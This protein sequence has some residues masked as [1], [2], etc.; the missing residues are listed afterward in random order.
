[1]T[2][3]THVTRIG[4]ALRMPAATNGELASTDLDVTGRVARRIAEC[5]GQNDTED[6]R[7][8]VS[9]SAVGARGASQ[10]GD[11]VK[12]VTQSLTS[13]WALLIQ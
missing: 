2:R 10:L 12:S 1:M 6:L 11:Q 9:F 3:L 5:T 7:H 13:R 8:L 4:F